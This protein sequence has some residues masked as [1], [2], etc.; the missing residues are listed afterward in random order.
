MSKL[1]EPIELR[2]VSIRNRLWVSPMNQYI[3][4]NGLVDDWHKI[5][6][7]QFSIGGAG[8]VIAEST[9]ISS[10]GRISPSDPGIWNDEQVT[11]WSEVTRLI[12][13]YGAKAALQINHAG[14]LASSYEPWTGIRGTIPAQKGGWEVTG[15]SPIPFFEGYETP[16][17]L[18][19]AELSTIVD[20]FAAAAKRAIAAGFDVLEIH[21]GHGYLIHQFISPLTNHRTDEFGGSLENR[22]RFLLQVIRAVR[23]A[24]GE[25]I[26][27]MV[28]YS[29]SDWKDG[30][31]TPEEIAQIVLW[32]TEAGA[33]LADVSTGGLH[34]DAVID[35]FPGYQAPFAKIVREQV[36]VPVSS[37]GLYTNGADAQKVLDD[38]S[39][40]VVIAGREWTRDPHLG[41]R[42]AKELGVTI[43]YTPRP[44]LKAYA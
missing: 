28:R 19:E 20:D 34:A 41:L 43:D 13:K 1:F 9:A 6:L 3:S 16:R 35:V 15:V 30:G 2:G 37:V 7:P 39:A 23:A 26:P 32:A 31:I 42:I 27:L 38:G 22:A 21:G 5:H 18:T 25:T 44:Y 11:A 40:D 8:M 12:R 33:D 17:E 14:R 36:S 24:I 4:E 29:A 10:D